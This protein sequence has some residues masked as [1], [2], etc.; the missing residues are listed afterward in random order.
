MSVSVGINMKTSVDVLVEVPC[1][2]CMFWDLL[3]ESASYCDPKK[4]Q[5]LTQWL[6]K[7]AENPEAEKSATSSS[8]LVRMV[9]RPV[10][11]YIS[12]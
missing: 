8:M 5:Q 2:R 12:K 1:F 6:L 3:R 11:N 10:A 7:Q 9:K 4:C